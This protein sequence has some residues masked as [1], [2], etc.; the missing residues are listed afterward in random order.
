MAD[1]RL[2]QSGDE[3]QNILDNAT[4]QSELTAETE[5]ALGAEQTLQGNINAEAQARLSQTQPFKGTLIRLVM[6]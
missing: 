2:T 5:R 3:V 4:P 6:T 1:Y